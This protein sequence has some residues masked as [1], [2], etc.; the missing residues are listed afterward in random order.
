MFVVAKRSRVLALMLFARSTMPSIHS[1]ASHS[2]FPSAIS[3][4]LPLASHQGCKHNNYNSNKSCNNRF[5]HHSFS[6]SNYTHAV[7]GEGFPHINIQ[8]ALFHTS[9]CNYASQETYYDILGVRAVATEEE[10][11]KAFKSLSKLWHPDVNASKNEKEKGIASAKYQLICEAFRCLSK[12]EERRKYNNTISNKVPYSPPIMPFEAPGY[13]YRDTYDKE[14]FESPYK[15]FSN[16]TIMWLAILFMTV[17][18]I[19]H[20]FNI[21]KSSDNFQV[22]LNTLSRQ[23]RDDYEVARQRAILNGPKKQL[24]ILREHHSGTT[25]NMRHKVDQHDVND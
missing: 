18:T 20:Y 16:M 15:I 19:G 8:T 12:P 22:Y 13:Q 6:S 4:V 2:F 24:D 23:A 11:R 1:F 9:S 10:I 17:A 25:I 3:V 14:H 7:V 21:K 5:K